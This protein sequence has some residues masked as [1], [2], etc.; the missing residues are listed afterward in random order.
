M[1][2]ESCE[3]QH[4]VLGPIAPVAPSDTHCTRPVALVD[5]GNLPDPCPIAPRD[6]ISHVGDPPLP[7]L[8]F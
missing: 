6:E 5:S 4:I 1:H 7:C 8:T 2:L 3:T